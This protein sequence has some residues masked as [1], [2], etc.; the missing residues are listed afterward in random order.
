MISVSKSITLLSAIN[1]FQI[2]KI[3]HLRITFKELRDTN[4]S[5]KTKSFAKPSKALIYHLGEKLESDF[6]NLVFSYEFV[7]HYL[8]IYTNNIH[9]SIIKNNS[10]MD[11]L[12]LQFFIFQQKKLY[13]LSLV[14]L[15]C[16]GE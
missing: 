16:A 6:Y 11:E 5:P 14:Q 9:F 8:Y 4:R 10:M 13:F 7:I 2:R 12:R 15:T 3:K 1:F